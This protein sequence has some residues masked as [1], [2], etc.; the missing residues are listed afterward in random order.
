LI[1]RIGSYYEALLGSGDDTAAG[2]V[3]D[4]L[5]RACESDGDA[6]VTLSGHAARVG[7]K[8]IAQAILERGMR[9]VADEDR[10][11]IRAEIGRLS[12]SGP[13]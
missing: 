10:P 8:E 3:A 13:D 1:R 2:L 7:R 9:A 11:R 12:E 4:K 6:Y 5:L